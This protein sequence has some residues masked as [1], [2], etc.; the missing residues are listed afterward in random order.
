MAPLT[1]RDLELSASFARDTTQLR[2]AHTA[3]L[4]AVSGLLG[5]DLDGIDDIQAGLD[6]LKEDLAA[7]G[8]VTG[9]LAQALQHIYR[10]ETGPAYT[11]SRSLEIAR[12]AL[13]DVGLCP[14]SWQPARASAF[15][16]SRTYAVRRLGFQWECPWCHQTTDQDPNADLDVSALCLDGCTQPGGHPGPCD[17]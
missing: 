8:Q 11:P 17:V 3:L 6:G 12:E 14:H 5:R 15:L 16:D 2:A 7:A 10:H 13:V 1:E 4:N 9:M